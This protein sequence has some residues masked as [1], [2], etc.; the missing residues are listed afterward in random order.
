MKYAV[1]KTGGKQYRVAEGDVLDVDRLSSSDKK[2]SFDSILLYVNDDSVLVGTPTVSNVLVK[3]SILEDTKGDKIRVSK[4]KA[5]V[6]Y[7][8]VT[9]FRSSLTKI[10]IDSIG[11]KKVA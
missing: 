11:L 9:G 1:I 10:K 3:A 2:I 5:K 6:R 4:Y 8:R 7:R